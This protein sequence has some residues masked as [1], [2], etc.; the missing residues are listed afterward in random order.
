MYQVFCG[1]SDFQNIEWNTIVLFIYIF[2]ACLF[3]NYQFPLLFHVIFFWNI[4]F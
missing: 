1:F 3:L 4:L 2:Y